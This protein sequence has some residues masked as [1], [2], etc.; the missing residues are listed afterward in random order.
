VPDW[1]ADLQKTAWHEF[2]SLPLPTRKD[3][4][5]RF[6]DLS[7]LHLSN[8]SPAQPA[9]ALVIAELISRSTPLEDSAGRIIFV[10]GQLVFQD[11]SL[12]RSGVS[13]STLAD[14]NDEGKHALNSISSRLGSGKFVS[15]HT[16]HLTNVVLISVPKKVCL[17]APIEIFHWNT[18]GQTAVFPRTIVQTKELAAVTVLE[19]HLSADD[20]SGFSCGAAQLIA[21][22]GSS[23]DY[24][25]SQRW[26]TASK[27]IH[28]SSTHCAKDSKV[29]H[30]LANLGSAWSRTECVSHLEGANSRSDMLSVSLTEES[31][32]VDQRTLQ[33]HHAP[34]ASS[35][36]LYKNVLFGKS[37]SIFAGLISVDDGA[38][39][40]DAYQTCRN[41]L[42][43]D[44]CE[45]NAMPGLEINADQVKCSHGSTSGAIDPEEIFYFESRGIPEVTAKALLA[46]GFLGQ[47][48]DRVSHEGIRTLLLEQI[49]QSFTVA[50]SHA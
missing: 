36:L 19:H 47:T 30:C 9:D 24:V 13:V 2:T 10:N 15:L 5:W 33:L 23:I 11:E 39:F 29:N 7:Q 45:A 28:L 44:D 21:G 35:D 43:S 48:L 3:E 18:G 6:A 4:A 41:L 37:R 38:H 16:A 34:H 40:T 26:N 12:A 8:F 31:Q 1:F 20:S 27:C 32:E 22:V 42:M 46:Q 14:D 50:V 25:L 49:A 17:A